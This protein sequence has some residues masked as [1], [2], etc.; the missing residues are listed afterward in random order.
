MFHY[1]KGSE[2]EHVILKTIVTKV[3]IGLLD[4][5]STS[6][7]SMYSSC[8]WLYQLLYQLIYIYI[9]ICIS[10]CIN[11]YPGCQIHLTPT[12]STSESCG[13]TSPRKATVATTKTRSP[14]AGR[15]THGGALT[16]SLHKLQCLGCTCQPSGGV[17][18]FSTQLSHEKKN[19]WLFGVDKGLYYPSTGIWMIINYKPLK[20]SVSNNQ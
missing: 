4:H 3:F 16:N 9:L 17:F 13:T 14:R 19:S 5:I 20:G 6:Q 15:F 7:V 2:G 18:V 10:I 12:N 11:F 1:L 8:S